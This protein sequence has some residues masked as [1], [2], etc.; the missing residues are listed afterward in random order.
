MNKRGVSQVIVQVLLI[1]LAIAATGILLLTIRELISTERIDESQSRLNCLQ[2]VDIE[3]LDVCYSGN[4]LHMTIKNNREL[5]LGDF[6]LVSITFENGTVLDVP[7]PY[8]TFINGYET[9]K[10]SMVYYLGTKEILVVPKIESQSFLCLDSAPKFTE[11]G[12]CENE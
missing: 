10:I 8:N 4:L 3:L 2:D 1:L 11:I 12:E 5:V 6:F 9:K 7:T